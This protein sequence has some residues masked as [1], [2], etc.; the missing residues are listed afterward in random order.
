[1]SLE[2]AWTMTVPDF[3]ALVAAH[4]K[5]NAG[6]EGKVASRRKLTPTEVQDLRAVMAQAESDETQWRAA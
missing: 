4:K 6:P 5:I 3:T 2:A 1:M